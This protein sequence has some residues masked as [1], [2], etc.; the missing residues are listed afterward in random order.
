MV[1]NTQVV[2]E[3]NDFHYLV[4]LSFSEGSPAYRPVGAVGAEE[5]SAVA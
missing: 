4:P 1:S 3:P 5:A 2:L